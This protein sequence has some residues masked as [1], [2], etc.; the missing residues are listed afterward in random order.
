MKGNSLWYV[1]VSLI[2]IHFYNRVNQ[3][4]GLYRAH[5]VKLEPPVV[6]EKRASLEL[7]ARRAFLEIQAH[8][9]HH[10]MSDLSSLNSSNLKV[11]PRKA[12]D[13]ILSPSSRLKLD[14]LVRAVP[15]VLP[16]PLVLRDSKEF[17]VK[18]ERLDP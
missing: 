6:Q 11:G 1:I 4:H 13:P 14:P 3:L 2:N 5:Q 16:V 7:P 15:P 10:L 9:D 12:L 17:A 8:L 18:P